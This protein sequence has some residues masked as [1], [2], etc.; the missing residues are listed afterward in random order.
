MVRLTPL[1]TVDVVFETPKVCVVVVPLFICG[2]A[3]LAVTVTATV[4]PGPPTGVGVGVVMVKLE[5]PLTVLRLISVAVKLAVPVTLLETIW[6]TMLTFTAAPAASVP[7][8]QEIV[9]TPGPPAVQVPN[10]VVAVRMFAPSGTACVRT[11]VNVVAVTSVAVLFVSVEVKVA[12]TGTVGSETGPVKETVTEGF[13]A[14]VTG[15]D[16][17]DSIP[18]P[19][20][21]IAWTVKV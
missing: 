3:E 9:V 4:G 5:L 1:T 14:G 21:L 2:F 11:K 17:V 8:L 12:C 15:L 16:G 18:F 10:P 6:T 19:P 7:M 13:A 20:A